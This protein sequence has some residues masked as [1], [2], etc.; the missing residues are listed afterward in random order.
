[1]ADSVGSSDVRF[2]TEEAM[3]CLTNSETSLSPN[4]YDIIVNSTHSLPPTLLS[5]ILQSSF[6]LKDC[7]LDWDT[8]ALY[9]ENGKGIIQLFHT[10]PNDPV[11][12]CRA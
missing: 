11:V 4:V 12:F 6:L 5:S 3:K 7:T 10:Q 1:M 8:V 2:D 9:L